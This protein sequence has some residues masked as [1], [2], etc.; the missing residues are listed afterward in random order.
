M[1]LASIHRQKEGFNFMR[2][3]INRGNFHQWQDLI[4]SKLFDDEEL[5][6]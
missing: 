6:N 3:K 2:F 1:A 5:E 4:S